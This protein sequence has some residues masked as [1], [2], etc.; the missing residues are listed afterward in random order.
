MKYVCGFQGC[1]WLFFPS[2]G[3]AGMQFNEEPR[4]EQIG[5]R[6][7][8]KCLSGAVLVVYSWDLSLKLFKN[9][10]RC[11]LVIL[12]LAHGI[13]LVMVQFD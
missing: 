8:E 3:T 10:K 11:V 9:L 2:E 12:W 13:L 6:K 4:E 1:T 5:E 7:F